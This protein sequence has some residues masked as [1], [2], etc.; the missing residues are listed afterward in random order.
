MKWEH[1]SYKPKLQLTFNRAFQS[2]SFA[3]NSLSRAA[4]VAVNPVLK[5]FLHMGTLAQMK[6]L[7]NGEIIPCIPLQ[8]SLHT[9]GKE[10]RKNNLVAILFITTNTFASLFFIKKQQ[11]NTT[12]PSRTL[13]EV[14]YARAWQM[15][16]TCSYC[17]YDRWVCKD[18]RPFF[19]Q[20][21]GR[22]LG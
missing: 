5:L 22:L 20:L 14:I 19:L 10:N 12:Q 2:K 1:P 15:P 11:Q 6:T 3:L 9:F 16:I 7:P 17:F 4:I 13:Q 18:L 8:I 21:W